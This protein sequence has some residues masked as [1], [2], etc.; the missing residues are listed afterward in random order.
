MLLEAVNKTKENKVKVK[1]SKVKET[2]TKIKE[3]KDKEILNYCK[4]NPPD[5]NQ[6]SKPDKLAKSDDLINSVLRTD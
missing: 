4:S 1:E 6:A 5:I 2:K 3:N